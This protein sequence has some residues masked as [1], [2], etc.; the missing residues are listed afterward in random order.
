MGEL[1]ATAAPAPPASGLTYD[2]FHSMYRRFAEERKQF[3]IKLGEYTINLLDYEEH[4]S[5]HIPNGV[6]VLKNMARSRYE[7]AINPQRT[8]MILI[9]EVEGKALLIGM[10]SRGFGKLDD[11][12]FQI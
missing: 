12:Y 10:E 6:R 11:V 3:E 8:D 4:K 9:F 7:Q 1:Y 5:E 2:K